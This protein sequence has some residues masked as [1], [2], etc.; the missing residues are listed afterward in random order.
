VLRARPELRREYEGLKREL[1]AEHD[2]LVAYSEGKTAFI[3]RLIATARSG[4]DLEFD[5]DLPA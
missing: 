4:D 2:D 1:S 5:F 3:E